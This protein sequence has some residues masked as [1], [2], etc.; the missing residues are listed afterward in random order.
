[1]TL[2]F[3]SLF[4]ALSISLSLSA[5]AEEESFSLDD[6]V[7]EPAAAR[8]A[9]TPA[10]NY[11]LFGRMDLTSEF[12]PYDRDRLTTDNQF[13]TQH[14][15]IFLSVQA[16][17]DLSFQ[18]E[19]IN[20]ESNFYFVNYE[21]GPRTNLQFG[22]ILV[23]FGETDYY[24][25]L[26]GGNVN[27]DGAGIMFPNIWAEKGVNLQLSWGKRTLDT[28]WVSGINKLDGSQEPILN[29]SSN[30]SLQ[31]GGVRWTESMGMS[32]RYRVSY[33]YTEWRPNSPLH[34]AGLD[35]KYSLPTNWGALQSIDMMAGVAV[36][37]IQK[38]NTENFQKAGDFFEANFRLPK[39]HSIRLRY[40]TYDNDDR[41]ED[42]ADLKT[43]S[44]AWKK[45]IRALNLMLEHQ[46]NMEQVNESENDILRFMATVNF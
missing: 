19:I 2:V 9:T 14:M 25:H 30:D 34:A 24:H 3:R 43:W 21:L 42:E 20:P 12:T 40:G 35:V 36:V 23:P 8:S 7:E 6:V 18:A 37:D 15:L 29:Q 39:K 13:K 41:V 4:L 10:A 31:G 38:T 32:F 16:Q 45:R 5:L 17:E 22:R 26:Y 44:L 33:Y 11:K 1:M 27:L 46:W 28:Y